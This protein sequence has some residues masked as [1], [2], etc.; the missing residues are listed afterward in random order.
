MKTTNT[1]IALAVAAALS[2]SAPAA[3]ATFV[4]GGFENGN[5]S[6]WT[7]SGGCWGGYGYNNDGC[8]SADAVPYT[9]VS[10]PL[11]P[12]LFNNAALANNTLMSAGALDPITNAP[13]VY[14]GNY[15]VRVNDA[16]NN[17]SVST[18]KQSV[19]NYT[20]PFLYFAWDAV[21][22]A[23]HG[24][25]DSDYFSLVLRDDTKGTD[26]VTRAYSSAGSI[27]SGAGP[28]VWT[29]YS[30]WYSAGWVTE[31]ID[32][33]AL[34]A[35]G[36]D[37]TLTLL[38]SDCPYGGHAGYAYLDGFGG[39]PPV[40]GVPEPATLGLLGLGLAG[41]ALARKRKMV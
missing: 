15:S 41:M 35:I 22:Q 32:L 37:L 18:I 8:T 34:N 19:T 33:G 38:A 39:T 13:V 1:L 3:A 24:L 11:D 14:S 12:G 23:S 10:L 30:G 29:D 28:L 36:D 9:G 5:L 25:T 27:G 26:I 6:G 40:Q 4:N 20:D 21:L 2:V 31:S 7:G 16:V 17:Y